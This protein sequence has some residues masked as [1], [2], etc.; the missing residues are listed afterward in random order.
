MKSFSRNDIGIITMA[1]NPHEQIVNCGF[2]II[3]T[4][5][6][7]IYEWDFSKGWFKTEQAIMEDYSEIPQLI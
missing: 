4:I 2:R 7:H 5:D 1:T 3:N 6:K